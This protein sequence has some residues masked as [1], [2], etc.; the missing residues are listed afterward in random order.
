[1]ASKKDQMTGEEVHIGQNFVRRNVLSEELQ[2]IM[3]K[4][5]YLTNFR[6]ASS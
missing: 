2:D 3:S 1:M 5:G 4:K 6:E